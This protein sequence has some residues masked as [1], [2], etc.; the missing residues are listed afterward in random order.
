M[1]K[2]VVVAP[3]WVGD[4]LMSL[5]L[6]GMLAAADGLKTAVLASPYTSRI[7]L[8]LPGVSELIVFAGKGRLRR[9]ADAAE[10]LRALGANGAL[11]LPPSFSSALA[12]WLGRVP[13]RVG[14]KTDGRAPL[15]TAALD[16][17][18]LKEEHLSESYI[19][20]GKKILSN[21]NC[22]APLI[23]SRPCIRIFENEKQSI[24][25]ILKKKGAA[26]VHFAVVVPG[27]T[28]GTAKSWPWESFRRLVQL[29]SQQ[30]PVVLGGTDGERRLCD[31]IAFGLSDVFNLAGETTLGE[32]AALL[33]RAQIVVANDSGAP[34][35]AASLGI[36]VVVIF[37]ST[38]P[39]WTAPLGG[40]VEIARHPVPCSPC[41]LR[42]CPSSKEC[43][44]GIE[45]EHVLE[46]VLEVLEKKVDN[47]P[48]TL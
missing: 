29:L 19:R 10:L 39:R 18:N 34:H 42:E 12:A 20:L 26:D 41:F 22:E 37:G 1:K 40:Q 33:Q 31:R 23:F 38:S 16:A 2:V 44:T 8:G 6:L 48:L 9:V 13:E 30:L 32:L 25:R 45:P 21:W 46:K 43:F 3:N 7:Y 17:S 4:A 14:Y 36:P 27:A 11:L 15:L 28:Y 47:F 35:I 5:P 24:E